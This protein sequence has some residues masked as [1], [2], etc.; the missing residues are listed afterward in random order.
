MKSEFRYRQVHLDFHTSEHIPDVGSNFNAQQ[1]V[2]ALKAGNVDSIT[3]FAKC[4]H[5]WSYFPTK[6]GKVHPSLKR[7]L[8]GEMV[9]ACKEADIN[10]PAYLSVQWDELS[11]REHPEWRVIRG[12][13]ERFK[14]ENGDQSDQS[15]LTACWHPLCLNQ[16][17]YVDYLIAHTLEV[18]SL[19]KVDGI[20]LDIVIPYDCVCGECIKSMKRDGL[21]PKKKEDRLENHRNVIMAHYKRMHAAV[22][23]KDPT[24][25]LFHNSGHIYKNERDRLPFFTHLELESLPT[26]GWGYDHFP[27]SARYVNTLGMEYLGMTGKFHTSWGEFG[28]FKRAKALEYECLSMLA[29]G[30]RCSVGDQLHPDGLMDM[31]TY[32]IIGPAYG[33]VKKIEQFVINSKALSEVA[34][35]SAEGHTHNRDSEKIDMGAARFL[36]EEQIMFDII[37]EDAD[38]SNYKLIVLPDV[39]TLEGSLLDKIRMYVRNGGKLILTGASGMNPEKNGF[40]VDFKATVKGVSDFKPDYMVCKKGLDDRLP[41]SPFVV[42]DRAYKVKSTGAEILAETRVPYFNREWDHFCSH[43]HTPYRREPNNEY[44]GILLDGNVA[45]FSHPICE[46]YFNWGQ[47]LYKY[48]FIAVLR[49]LL[50]EFDVTVKM[51]SSGRISYMEQKGKNRRLLHVVYAQTQYRGSAHKIEILED[52]VPLQQ[53]PCRVKL[54]VKPARIYYGEDGREI[55]FVYKN[56]IAEFVLKDIDLHAVAVIELA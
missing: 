3:V 8:L 25:R 7:D 28:G 40:A 34:I 24:M 19:Y 23:A 45:Y 41:E 21:N 37:D 47:P 48:A 14:V 6:T 5:G 49:K 33:R 15:Q 17:G 39:I 56:G 27:V 16:K 2:N 9:K 18:M 36:N 44:D 53:A 26:G 11:A 13:N 52:A 31:D 22:E 10:I 12:Q 29:L 20:F 51:P 54:P 1:F 43:K 46:T 50:P 55:P 30:A 4:H 35:F 38:F 32:K 42:Y